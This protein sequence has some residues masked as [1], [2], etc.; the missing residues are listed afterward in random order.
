M[1]RIACLVPGAAL[2]LA[3]ACGDDDGATEQG[4]GGT[5]AADD[6]DDD[7][8]SA[9]TTTTATTVD[10][11][12]STGGVPTGPTFAEDVAPILAEHCWSCHLEGGIA[13]FPLL[14]YEDAHDFG[15][16]IVAA[17]E[18]RYMPPWPLDGSGA[19]N[20][21]VDER[22]LDDDEIATLAAW[23]DAGRPPGDL[24]LVP[25]PPGEPPHLEVVSAT[26][27]IEPYV[28][29]PD[30]P[31]NPFDD[32]R[33]FVVDPGLTED[34]VL[35]ALEV[36]PGV[37]AQAHHIV[38]FALGTD[39]AEA[40]AL[41]Q[42]GADGRPGYPCF[43]GANVANASIAG[44]WAPG[45][46]I[47]RFP[48]GT[49][50]PVPAGRSMVLQMHYN[51]AAGGE[52]DATTVDV[53]FDDSAIALRQ[54]VVIDSDLAIPPETV[55]HVEQASMV[56]GAEPVEIVAAFPHMHTLG[57]QLRV[58]VGADGCAIDV[59]RWDFHWQQLYSYAE[60]LVIPGGAEVTI[61][62]S[63]DSTGRDQVTT[64]GEGTS[65]EMC[66]ALF[67]ALP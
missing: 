27:A 23:V 32:Y 44:A 33:C 21:F 58:E 64:F 11:D 13:P 31:A 9:P 7:G 40:D 67:F 5:T 12:D 66:V 55:G 61:G 15:P 65:D 4:D 34:S 10:P 30:P 6:D 36:H 51:L 54:I 1:K 43:G 17:T 3:I 20:S 24:T 18:T 29:Q 14:T 48:E 16:S 26:L 39:D 25:E 35:T 62:C 49:G 50:A 38:L 22:W 47:M 45:V 60:P 8:T 46:P 2:V 63:Y 42:S 41:A 37:A 56:L 57:R 28:P 52:E 59:P 53:T 19:C